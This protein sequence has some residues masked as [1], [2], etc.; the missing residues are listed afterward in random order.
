MKT[1][2]ADL[3][4]KIL[5]LASGVSLCIGFLLTELFSSL[6]ESP[7]YQRESQTLLMVG[8]YFAVLTAVVSIKNFLN[9]KQQ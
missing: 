1:S 9:T 3:L 5:A 8:G 7:L 2:S 4:I 6:G